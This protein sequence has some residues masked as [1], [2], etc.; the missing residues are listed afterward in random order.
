MTGPFPDELRAAVDR[1][2]LLHLVARY[3]DVVTRR[4]WPE[5]AELFLPDAPVH[6]ETVTRPPFTV[7]GPA[8]LGR[9]VA[10][11]VEHFDFFEF[12]V[13]NHVLELAVDGDADRATG[14]VFMCE[15]R[16]HGG[17]GRFSRAYGRYTDRY[18]RVDGRWWIEG[19]DYRSMARTAADG[20]ADLEVLWHPDGT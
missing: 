16:Q 9:F 4:A 14:R 12:V 13:L 3:A 7:R 19:R 2:E 6:I 1:S 5:L 10:G 17:T 11:A 20:P 15:L 18:R 8:E